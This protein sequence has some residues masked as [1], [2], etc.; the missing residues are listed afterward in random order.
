[1]PVLVAG[2]RDEMLDTGLFTS[3]GGELMGWAHQ[4]FA[5]FLAGRYLVE[6]KV[7]PENVLKILFH[8]SGGDCGLTA[9][10]EPAPEKK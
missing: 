6:K 8:P 3:R 1:V 5:E 2:E 9:A 4:S 7:S 10:E